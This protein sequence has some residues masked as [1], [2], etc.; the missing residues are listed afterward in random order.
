MSIAIVN[1]GTAVGSG[2]GMISASYFVAQLG[3]PWQYMM[4]FTFSLIMIM[5]FIFWKFILGNENAEVAART[6][7][8][9]EIPREKQR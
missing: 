7:L 5:V 2:L 1:S 9:A 8:I 3:M 6:Q 4:F